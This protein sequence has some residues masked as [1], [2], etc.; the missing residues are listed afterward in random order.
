[1]LP[2]V[3]TNSSC[4]T[5]SAR[6]GKAWVTAC[7]CHPKCSME[8]SRKH[9][10]RRKFVKLAGGATAVLAAGKSPDAVWLGQ[11]GHAKDALRSGGDDQAAE[12]IVVGAGAFGCSTAW[13]LARKGIS[14]LVLE[15]TSEPASQTTRGGAGF[16]ASWSSVHV[17][18]WGKTEWQMQRYGIDFYAQLARDCGY[19]IGFA[20]CGIAYIYVTQQGWREVQPRVERARGFGTKIEC[21][22]SQRARSL[23]PVINFKQTAGILFDPDAVRVRAG[24]AIR[25]LAERL[26][27]RGVRFQYNSAVTGFLHDGKRILGVQTSE[28]VYRARSVVVTAGAWSRPLVERACGPCPADPKTETRYTTKPLAGVEAQMPLLIF[29]DYLGLYIREELGGLLIGGSDP[30]PLPEDRLVDSSSPP[31]VDKIPPDQAYRV[32]EYIRQI[33]GVMPVLKHAEVDKITGGLP[34]FT[35]DLRF[36]IDEVP[37]CRGLYVIAGCQEAGITHGPALGRMMAELVADGHATWD[38]DLYR[39]DRFKVGRSAAP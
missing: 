4:S 5:T 33:E 25:C 12:V 26:A 10:S 36:I 31:R 38:R 32:R 24:D 21:L 34:T 30:P 35:S 13:H 2:S 8:P 19:D 27:A 23:F 11:W 14:V 18:E 15:A 3:R 39:I 9:I 6:E 28:G 29:S 22:D 37:V 16:V 7:P 20:A 1:M 17:K